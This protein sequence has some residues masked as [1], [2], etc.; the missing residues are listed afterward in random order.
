[1]SDNIVRLKVI[2]R[3][4][5]QPKDILEAIAKDNP[6]NVFVISWP[7]DGGMP[8]YHSSTGD[9]PTVLMRIQGFIHKFYNN[10]FD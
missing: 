9:M 10:D 1:M 2:T 3:L 6:K 7:E 4:D 8:T 5:L